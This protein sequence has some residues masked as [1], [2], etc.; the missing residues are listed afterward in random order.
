MAKEKHK[1]LDVIGQ[2]IQNHIV[3]LMVVGFLL[4]ALLVGCGFAGPYTKVNDWEITEYAK[5]ATEDYFG[6]EPGHGN[7]MMADLDLVLDVCWGGGSCNKRGTIIIHDD[8]DEYICQ[9]IMHELGHSALY[10]LYGDWDVGDIIGQDFFRGGIISESCS[11]Y[12]GS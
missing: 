5:K 9:Q 10:Q 1:F 7:I 12:N 3:F 2:F 11:I 4:L 6:I 8:T